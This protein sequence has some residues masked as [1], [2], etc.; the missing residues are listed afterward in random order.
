MMSLAS[1]SINHSFSPPLSPY[2][3]STTTNTCCPSS[4]SYFSVKVSSFS[5]SRTKPRSLNCKKAYFFR[6][7][8]E[9]SERKKQGFVVKADSS[10]LTI[11]EVREAEEEE[12]PPL[13]DSENNARPRRI[14]LF[15]EPSPFA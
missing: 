15:V 1:L 14:A 8:S 3:C 6:P 9:T 13:I 7:I 10:N 2:L 4:R 12:S 5:S 11:T